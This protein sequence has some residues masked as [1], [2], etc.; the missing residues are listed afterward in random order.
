MAIARLLPRADRRVIGLRRDL[1]GARADLKG[2]VLRQGT[3]R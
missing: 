2:R 3:R 1:C